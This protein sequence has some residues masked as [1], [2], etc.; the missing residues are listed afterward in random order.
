MPNATLK[1]AFLRQLAHDVNAASRDSWARSRGGFAICELGL[2][3]S[4]TELPLVNRHPLHIAG[5]WLSNTLQIAEKHYLL[6]SDADFDEA[7]GIE[8][9]AT[10]KSGAECGAVGAQKAISEPASVQNAVQHENTTLSEE[11]LGSLQVE[12]GMTY[13]VLA[14]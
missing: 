11:V 14:L 7:A 9:E 10:N 6:T 5:R 8:T 12:F 1:V 4:S 2:S 3:E 13:G